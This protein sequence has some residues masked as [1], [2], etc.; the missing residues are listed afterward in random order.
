MDQ[1]KVANNTEKLNKN[2]SSP[3]TSP[4]SQGKLVSKVNA[5]TANSTSNP[6]LNPQNLI[7]NTEKSTTLNYKVIVDELISISDVDNINDY[8]S[9]IYSMIYQNVEVNFFAIGLFKEKS[10]CINLNLQD[11]LENNYST[12]VF[13][14]D[15]DYPIVLSQYFLP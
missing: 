10:N 4:I 1:N 9:K 8:Y 12:K 2:F 6:I 15:E 5:L 7:I 14:K 13:L 11:K 3:I